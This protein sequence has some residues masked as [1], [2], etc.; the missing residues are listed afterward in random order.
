MNSSVIPTVFARSKK[1]FEERFEKLIKVSE[2]I[3]IDFMDGKFVKGR[4]IRVEDIPYLKKY[5]NNFEAHLMVNNPEKYSEKLKKKGFKKIIFHIESVNKEGAEKLIE[6]IKKLRMEVFVAI[7]PETPVMDIVQL[8]NKVDGVLVM[9]VHPGKEH[10]H[11]IPAVYDKIK[12]LRN[13][14]EKIKIQIDGGVNFDNI[15]KLKESGADF[16]NSGSLVAEAENPKE[17]IERLSRE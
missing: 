6:R 2:Y 4:S 7:N 11:F 1:E 13:F 3:Q 5:K 9:G 10:Q 17:I 15:R 12:E 14:K 8:I 16:I